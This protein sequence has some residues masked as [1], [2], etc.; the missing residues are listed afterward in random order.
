[1]QG[2]F[3]AGPTPVQRQD[4]G[5]GGNATGMPGGLRAGLEGLSGKDLSGVRVRRNSS[6]P[7]QVNALAY[8][9]GKDIHVAPGQE[10]HLPHEGW[11]AVQ[12][13]Q[14]RVKPTI[15][16]RGVSINDDAGLE[17]EADVMG[18]KAVQMKR[19]SAA[20]GKPF[21]APERI[22][23]A[24]QGDARG[25]IQREPQKNISGGNQ[26]VV[27]ITKALH[28]EMDEWSP[29]SDDVVAELKKLN[30]DAGKINK[31]K[32]LYTH[33]YGIS[34]EAQI[35]DE[36]NK[37]KLKKILPL[38]DIPLAQQES[39][40]GG[41]MVSMGGPYRKATN[42]AELVRLVKAAED[43]LIS[44]GHTEVDDRMKILRGIYYGTTWSMDYQ[45]EGSEA[46]NLG[47]DVYT[48]STSRPTDPRQML[49][50]DLFRAL[51]AT[52]EL[53]DGTR[54]VDW[55]HLIIGL[56]ARSK[57][58]AREAALPV[59]GGTGL[60]ITTWL[61]DLGGGAGM[62]AMRRRTKP[63]TKAKPLVFNASGH[64]Y[65]ATINLEGDIA[66]YVVA[67]DTSETDDPSYPDIKEYGYV[68]EAI[69]DYL[70]PQGGKTSSA[71]NNRVKIFAL[72]IGAEVKGNKITNKSQ[73]KTD[74]TEQ[75]FKFAGMY[76]LVRM[77]D[78][79]TASKANYR[80]TSKYVRGAATEV[81]DIFVEMLDHCIKT[82]SARLVATINPSP[83]PP[84]TPEGLLKQAA[85]SIQH[86]EDAGKWLDKQRRKLGF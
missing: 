53:S 44:N 13:M 36:F 81:A 52:P 24:Q 33:L 40:I 49:G 66:A 5:G 58:I 15:Q 70:L 28:T 71:W 86:G 4:D 12:Q 38:I 31:V 27:A 26:E 1:M 23:T 16:A 72:M 79:G 59:Q 61:G 3:I 48:A 50:N 84:G 25:V 30:K 43:I 83:S 51:R 14:G 34:L 73:M 32:A 60:E 22:P 69:A 62:L 55:G 54:K 82:P 80:E 6:K 37:D 39:Y 63:A 8:T 57:T 2:R 68:A 75:L 85:D 9:Q 21:I 74:I 41:Q 46:R 42:F 67:Y 29:D 7:A 78:N 17:R 11:H 10:R 47:F 18:A 20:E 56:E 35:R 64:D 65:G 19:V 45:K 76:A 77:A